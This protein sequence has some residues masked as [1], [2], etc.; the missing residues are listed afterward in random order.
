M[1]IKVLASGS[2]GNCY[3][4]SDG[5][6]KVLLD[7]GI[8]AKKIAQGLNFSLADIDACLITHEHSDHVKAAKD[9]SRLGIPIYLTQG[10]FDSLKNTQYELMPVLARIVKA[11]RLFKV[12]SLTI[13]PFKTEHDAQEPCGYLIHSS[14]THEKL[15]YITDSFYVRYKFHG[16]NYMLVECNYTDERLQQN[17]EAGIIP[18]PML[19]RLRRS[20]MSLEH[21]KEFIKASDIK[22]LKLIYLI[23]ISN[24]NGDIKR[25][26]R[27]IKALTGV[28]VYAV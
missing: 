2:S 27:E 17:V 28:E 6:T 11:G 23:H 10:S 18:A 8:T 19:E 4:I 16:V 9:L 22:N 13:L 26:V 1:K 21:L 5:K 15:L 12:K 20:H 7:A 3:W 14:E 25:M 24:D